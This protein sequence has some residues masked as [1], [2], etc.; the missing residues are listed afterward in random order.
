MPPLPL[1]RLPGVVLSEVFKS[2]SIGEKIKLSLC[3]KK[4][5]SQINN[6]RLYSQK[7]IVNLSTLYH[8][9]EVYTENKKDTFD[10]FNCSDSGTINNPYIQLHRIEGRAVP[11]ISIGEAITTFWKDCREG[12]LSVIRYLLKIF[13][14]KIAISNNCNSDLYQPT[15]SE[16][17][18]LQV[19]F[20]KLTIHFKGSNDENLFWKHIFNKLGQVEDLTILCTCDPDFRPVFTSWPQNIDVLSSAWFTLENL[21]ECPCTTITLWNSTLG[22]KDLDMILNNWKTGGFPNLKYLKIHSWEIRCNEAT[23]LD[24]KFRELDGMVIQTDDGSKKATFKLGYQ[25]IEM[26]VTLL[27]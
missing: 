11:V 18:D 16:L 15:V 21:L 5:S 13:Q 19:A 1:L 4:I 22:N 26:S 12:Y 2:L 25:R 9:I 3:S 7:V 6:A 23:I 24:M 17:F 14:C 20:K 27:Q 10:I 8:N